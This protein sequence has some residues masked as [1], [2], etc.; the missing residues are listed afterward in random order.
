MYK[1][2]WEKNKIYKCTVVNKDKICI[3]IKYLACSALM[4]KFDCEK[5]ELTV[6]IAR[7]QKKINR[8]YLREV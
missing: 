5:R 3:I 4:G 7:N 8:D 1:F 2:S 6:N